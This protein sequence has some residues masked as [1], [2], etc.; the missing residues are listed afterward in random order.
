M[1][2]LDT[3]YITNMYDATEFELTGDHIKLLKN[4]NVD[5]DDCETGAP[6]ID[7]KRPY[8]NSFVAGDV[9]EILYE[10]S[11]PDDFYDDDDFKNE[12]LSIHNE[13]KTALQI[14]LITGKFQP[15]LYKRSS[16]WENNWKLVKA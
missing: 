11:P 6:C 9:Y 14:I 8:G 4:A 7:P 10:K 5:W 3:D 16:N 2:G 1:S 12:L 13:T 15:G